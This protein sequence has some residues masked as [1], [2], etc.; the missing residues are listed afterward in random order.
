MESFGS[1]INIGCNGKSLKESVTFRF[2]GNAGVW[3]K[4]ISYSLKFAQIIPPVSLEAL[5]LSIQ[6]FK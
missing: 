1:K 2:Y 3:D 4:N 6:T 5:A